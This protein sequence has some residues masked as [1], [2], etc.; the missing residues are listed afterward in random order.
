MDY[1]LR[2]ISP[3]HISAGELPE[4]GELVVTIARIETQDVTAPGGKITTTGVVYF[5]GWKKGMVLNSGNGKTIRKLYGKD[6]DAWIGKPIAL[7]RDT[8]EAFGDPDTPCIRVRPKVP[9]SGRADPQPNEEAAALTSKICNALEAATTKEAVE[10]VAT[11]HRDAV[12]KLPQALRE[13]VKRT[14]AAMIDT[15][16]KEPT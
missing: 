15:F 9:S 3:L 11:E 2:R 5:K 16:N 8:T 13:Q 4:K 1:R 10:A 12:A 6:D 14:K 7:Y